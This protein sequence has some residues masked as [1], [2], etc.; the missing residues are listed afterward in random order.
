MKQLF[1]A[2]VLMF[3]LYSVNAQQ[4]IEHCGLDNDAKL[5]NDE[6]QFLNNYYKDRGA[7]DFSEKKL[8]FITGGGGA[9][10]SSKSEYFS[11]VKQWKDNHNTTIET[12]LVVLTSEEK[13]SSGGYDAI[14]LFWVKFFPKSQ[15]Q[16]IILRL[17][18]GEGLR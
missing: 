6:A 5:N 12:K 8:A 2:F 3:F 7:F 18:S 15:K 14:I 16:K 10:I 4:I 17:G 13:E 1:T 9:I 11:H